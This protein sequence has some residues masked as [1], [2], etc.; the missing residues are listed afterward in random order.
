M[1]DVLERICAQT[2]LDLEQRKKTFSL[3]DL[4][5][6]ATA[7]DPARG[8]A[9]AL[10]QH[11][12]QGRY[13]LICEIKKASPSGGLIRPDFDPS[14]LA[15]AYEKG[16]ASCLSVLTDVPFFQGSDAYLV[17][18]RAACS[19]P[20]LRK[21]FMLDPWQIVESRALGADC[22]LL[23][24]AALDK[25]LLA[26]MEAL[27]LSLGMDAL[28][29]VHDEYEM[30]CALRH[31]RSGLI[32]VNN[33]NLRTLETNLETTEALAAMVGKDRA[34]VSESGLKQKADLD[35]IAK[36]GARRFLVGESLMRQDDV[37]AATLRLAVA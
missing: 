6:K 2:R 21:D 15:K 31:T 10:D 20:V 30:E 14:A 23:I 32:G 5:D 29:E 34:L 36:S 22:V 4:E 26:D 28:I 33:R 35:R 11:V 19:L 7:A 9:K 8:F 3:R 16:G 27:A 1:S 13:G 18:A 37:E 17:A 12:E 25:A 24:V